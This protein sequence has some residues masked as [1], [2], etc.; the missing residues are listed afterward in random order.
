MSKLLLDDEPL[1]ILPKLAAAIGLNEAI[2]LQQLHYWLEKSKNVRDGFRWVYN[3]YEEWQKQFP[4][5]SESTIKRTIK[6]LEGQHLIIVGKYNKLKIDNTKWY[7]ID[8]EVLQ[9]IENNT[10][11]QNDQTCDHFDQTTGQNDQ[12]NRAKWSGGRGNMDRPLPEITTETTTDKND[13]VDKH[14][15]IDEEFQKSYNYLL[16]NNIALSE[17]A[18]QDLGEFSDV[19]GSQ[20]IMEAVDR[21][22]DQNAKRWK[23]ISGILFNWQKSNVK[24][25]ADVIKLDEDYK[26]QR[27]GVGNATRRKRTGSGYGTSR[28]YEEENAS[29]ERNMPSFIKRV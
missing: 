13:D 15:L 5:W 4:F 2:I 11:G 27:G 22:V 8:Y 3:T 26:N 7:R 24:T 21:A 10:T 20:I 1:V 19:L 16:Q 25:L 28:S 9:N 14:P 12:T 29:R 6:K 23:Y 18:M 17:T